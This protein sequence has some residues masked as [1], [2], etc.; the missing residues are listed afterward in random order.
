MAVSDVNKFA[1]LNFKRGYESTS[2]LKRGFFPDALGGALRR[3]DGSDG[4]SGEIID[5]FLTHRSRVAFEC[6]SEFSETPLMNVCRTLHESRLLDKSRLGFVLGFEN[7]IALLELLMA[8]KEKNLLIVPVMN[9]IQHHSNPAL[10]VKTLN[11]LA[12]CRLLNEA[13]IHAVLTHANIEKL[14]KGIDDLNAHH[15]LTSP[16]LTALLKHTDLDLC[17]V[18]MTLL[19]R[20]T[21]LTPTRSHQ[22]LTHANLRPLSRLLELGS[23]ATWLNQTLVDALFK[24]S[25]LDRLLN[26]VQLIEPMGALTGDRLGTLMKHPALERIITLVN[27]FNEAGIV[28]SASLF[29]K[30]LTH[31]NLGTLLPVIASLKANQLF[32]NTAYFEAIIAHKNPDVLLKTFMTLQAKGLMN[33]GLRERLSLHP[34]ID[35]LLKMLQAV[36]STLLTEETI[37]ALVT[38]PKP[39]IFEKV[40]LQ[41]KE[42]SL[43]TGEHGSAHLNLLLSKPAEKVSECLKELAQ[44]ELLE[45]ADAEENFNAVMGCSDALMMKVVEALV[46][47]NNARLLDPRR[48]TE[49]EV[50]ANRSAVA[51][52]AH[53][54]DVAYLLRSLSVADLLFTGRRSRVTKEVSEANRLAVVTYSSPRALQGTFEQLY[55]HNLSL[56]QGFFKALTDSSND[57]DEISSALLKLN[58]ANYSPLVSKMAAR[59][60]NPGECILLLNGL[61]D[62]QLLTES[63]AVLVV[64]HENPEAAASMISLLNVTGDCD[65]VSMPSPP[66]DSASID[67]VPGPSSVAYVVSGARLF[68]V[69]KTRNHCEEIRLDQYQKQGMQSMIP[70][71]V[72]ESVPVYTLK[73][74]EWRVIKRIT[75]RLPSGFLSSSDLD[76]IKHHQNLDVLV[77]AMFMFYHEH[78]LTRSLFNGLAAHPNI[79]ALVRGLAILRNHDLLKDRDRVNVVIEADDPELS[80]L[81]GGITLASIAGHTESSMRAL[82]KAEEWMLHSVKERYYG[83]FRDQG[84]DVIFKALCDELEERYNAKKAVVTCGD[85]RVVEL[86]QPEHYI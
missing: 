49:E 70:R 48:H 15:C 86:P 59:S 42:T 46:I 45:Q 54:T 35:G 41:L 84:V 36:P 55:R 3:Y 43:L 39:A 60:A 75:T 12:A 81:S 50:R 5:A 6:I 2:R 1:F 82:S 30:L 64:E 51:H 27:A 67:S 20:H 34:S 40:L 57:I 53:P 80:A 10:I 69:D 13:V 73:P 66:M 78:S 68:Y 72:N 19:E 38:H 33:D 22:L 37:M 71:F 14:S 74:E 9:G 79:K 56:T 77:D 47:L 25:Q 8:I 11:V 7:S 85:G 83:M 26:L 17:F 4:V 44:A 65:L 61:K 18:V 23:S 62:N 63:H 31:R 28:M 24:Y 21:L 76:L 29:D 32:T 16:N 52:H 58:Q